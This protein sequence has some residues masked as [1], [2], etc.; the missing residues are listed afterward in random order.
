MKKKRI[1]AL[2]HTNQLTCRFEKKRFFFLQTCI[3][4]Q[5]SHYLSLSIP[6]CNH[7]MNMT[8]I[9]EKINFQTELLIATMPHNSIAHTQT[10][11]AYI[12]NKVQFDLVSMSLKTLHSLLHGIHGDNTHI[13]CVLIFFECAH[14]CF[15]DSTFSQHFAEDSVIVAAAANGKQIVHG[16]FFV[17]IILCLPLRYC[18]RHIRRPWMR[19]VSRMIIFS[20]GW[21][22]KAETHAP[23]QP[24]T[25]GIHHFLSWIINLITTS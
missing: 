7:L 12:H 17:D 6:V 8:K 18:R 3:V 23:I 15:F 11:L 16:K 10:M 25:V 21:K 19:H 2:W 13:H 4:F 9:P 20:E 22:F 1:I 5:L 24:C 14:G